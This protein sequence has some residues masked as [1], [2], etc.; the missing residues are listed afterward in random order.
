MTNKSF[1]NILRNSE[2]LD[3]IHTDICDFKSIQTRAGK[4]YF[5]TFINDNTRYC[6]VYLLRSKDEALESFIQYKT[7][8]ENQLGKNIKVLRSDRGGEYESPFGEFCSQHG[9]IHQTIAPYSP[10]Q[11]GIAE[12]KNRTLKEMMNAMLISSSL[13]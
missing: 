7:E 5:I 9:I 1:Q 4:K 11:N 2:P 6:H 12:R 3:L 13:P 10:Q 8:V